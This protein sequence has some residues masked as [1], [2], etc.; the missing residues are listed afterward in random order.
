[1]ITDLN[2][3]AAHSKQLKGCALAHYSA[4]QKA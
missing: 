2:T 4:K 1:M 3:A